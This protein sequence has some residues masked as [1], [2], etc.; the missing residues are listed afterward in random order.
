MTDAKRKLPV[1]CAEIQDIEDAERSG[2]GDVW[3]IVDDIGKRDHQDFARYE[4]AVPRCKTCVHWDPS[5][6]TDGTMFCLVNDS[7]SFPQDGS[8]HCNFHSDLKS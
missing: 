6:S 4:P 2:A 1:L 7:F 5:C 8:G 3:C